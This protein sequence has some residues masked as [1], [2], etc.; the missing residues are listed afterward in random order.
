MTRATTSSVLRPRL[1]AILPAFL[2]SLGG[3]VRAQERSFPFRGA[4][5]SPDWIAPAG[6]ET[7]RFGAAGPASAEL[8]TAALVSE[9]PPALVILPP[10]LRG[11]IWVPLPASE[12]VGKHSRGR[13]LNAALLPMEGPGFVKIQ[14]LRKRHYGTDELVVALKA[15][16]ARYA[17]LYPGEARIQVGDMSGPKGGSLGRHGSHENG[18]DVDVAMIAVG[19][20]EQDPDR[21]GFDESFVH[22]KSVSSRFDLERNWA[23]VSLAV[24]SA[25][26]GRM[27]L[28]RSIKKAFCARYGQDPANEE[29]LRKLRPQKRHNDHFHLRL[30]CPPDD[31]RCRPQTPPPAGSGC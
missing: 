3:A 20:K 10:A 25:G 15:I 23:L 22:G 12:A 28:D 11:I 30:D 8:R 19:E 21:E 16:G 7:L 6:E 14:R 4:L 24:G 2:L 29:T 27:F 26:V 18:L 17:A 1:R 13:L 5:P 9:I 31:H